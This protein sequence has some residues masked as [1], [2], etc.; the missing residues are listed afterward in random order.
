MNSAGG[1]GRTRKGDATLT[2]KV[3]AALRAGCR[4][5]HEIADFTKI[6]Y[7]R[8]VTPSLSRLE[9]RGIARKDKA[10]NVEGSNQHAW[11]WTLTERTREE[12]EYEAAVYLEN[13]R[14][15]TADDDLAKLKKKAAESRRGK[16]GE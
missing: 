13:Q 7:R 8:G 6:P 16:K 3:E 2:D 5:S 10:F 14:R 15:K 9:K 1:T 12:S 11:E 4:T